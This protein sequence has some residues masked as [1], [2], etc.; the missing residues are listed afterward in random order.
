LAVVLTLA[1]AS[2]W[3]WE[4]KAYSYVVTVFLGVALLPL[5]GE[6][7]VWVFYE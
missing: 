1:G 4:N 5:L 7:I 2:V 6:V 3:W